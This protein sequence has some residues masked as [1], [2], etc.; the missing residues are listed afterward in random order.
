MLKEIYLTLYKG[1]ICL[2]LLEEHCILPL[3]RP[4]SHF[5]F[6][7]LLPQVSKGNLSHAELLLVLPVKLMARNY[8]QLLIWDL[9]NS[10][11]PP[12]RR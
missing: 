5:T 12:W 4:L 8:N 6:N 2:S 7:Q 1:S 10:S 11:S 3:E 9:T